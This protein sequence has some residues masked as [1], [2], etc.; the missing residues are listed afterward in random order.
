[1]QVCFL[2]SFIVSPQNPDCSPFFKHQNTFRI[3]FQ[4]GAPALY[5]LLWFN[6]VDLCEQVSVLC[7]T[8]EERDRHRV[9]RDRLSCDLDI[10]W[11]LRSV[12]LGAAARNYTLDKHANKHTWTRWRTQAHTPSIC[13]VVINDCFQN[14]LKMDDLFP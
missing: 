9:W 8:E 13:L 5:S 2:A 7:K 1:M 3:S 12:V 6:N 10:T 11:T 4:R 14:S